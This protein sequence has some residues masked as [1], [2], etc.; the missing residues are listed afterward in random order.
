MKNSIFGTAVL[1]VLQSMGR[2]LDI[3]LDLGDFY[4]A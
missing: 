3:A 1:I 2:I 4:F